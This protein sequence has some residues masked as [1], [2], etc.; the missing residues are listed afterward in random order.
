MMPCHLQGYTTTTHTK[1]CQVAATTPDSAVPFL[2]PST[3]IQTHPSY[4]ICISHLISFTTR[5]KDIPK[6][7]RSLATYLPL[8]ITP[9]RAPPIT[10]SSCTLPL[11]ILLFTFEYSVNSSRDTALVGGLAGMPRMGAID[12]GWALSIHPKVTVPTSCN[13][14]RVGVPFNTFYP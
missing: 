4:T 7:P 10:S 14:S 3:C 6:T 2:K 13:S 9:P 8:L 1:T 12:W 5:H 11:P